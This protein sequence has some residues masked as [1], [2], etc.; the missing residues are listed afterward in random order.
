[1]NQSKLDRRQFLKGLGLGGAGV[2]LAGCD[3]PSYVTLEQGEENVISYL[4]PNEYVIPGVGVWYASTCVGCSAG[5]GIHG[6]V[7]EG[8]VL[9]LEGNPDSGVNMGR[10][11]QMGQAA[12]QHHFNPDRIANPMVRKNGALVEASWDEAIALI[13]EKSK[14]GK[15][16]WV[17]G[18]IS[19]HQRVMAQTHLGAIGGSRH[20]A[21]E[22]INA[23][24]WKTACKDIINDPNPEIHLEKAKVIFS[25]GADF[26][27]TFISPVH[28]AASY[29]EFRTPPRG[30]LIQ[31]EP[32][33]SLT[34][35][36]ADHWVGI[37]P[38]SETA[39]A[40]GVANAL[41]NNHGVAGNGISNATKTLINK[42][43]PETV[44]GI[45]AV[46]VGRIEKIA[47]SLAANSPS[48][49]LAGGSATGNANGYS[50]AAAALMLNQM[51]GNIGTTITAGRELAYP[52]LDLVEGN[53]ANLKDLAIDANE[54]KIDVLFVSGAN[55]LFLAP[56]SL[57]MLEGWNKVGFKVVLSSMLDETAEAA[58]VVLP[59]ASSLEDWGSHIPSYAKGTRN[60]ALQ[61]PLM[62]PVFPNTRGFGDVVLALAKDAGAPGLDDYDDYYGYLRS[63]ISALKKTDSEKEW[64]GFL[65]AG[66]TQIPSLGRK[67]SYSDGKIT[68]TMNDSDDG[69]LTLIAS[70]RMGMW[71]G[72][73][74]NLPWLQESPD[75]ISKV[76]WD[77]WAELHPK[78]AKSLGIKDGDYINIKS[79]SGE[80]T[81]RA[82]I[83]KG[84]HPGA[85]AVPI[86]R[87]HSALG[88]YAKDNGVNPL[89]IL[90]GASDSKT[91]EIATTATKVSVKSAGKNKQ[92]AKLM[93]I[94]RQ[95]GRKLVATISADKQR[96][97]EG[98]A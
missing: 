10:L 96:R 30:T 4:A 20:Y 9:K 27:G 92:M 29:A 51:L 38:G 18:T 85:I 78:T 65:M 34:G 54:G 39:L 33:M 7:R 57:K 35:G 36:N 28:F 26:L 53:S 50:A 87:G 14:S 62:E 47:A 13:N 31:A 91:G 68:P 55:P 44:A 2:A 21:V 66:Q 41:M 45:C 43:D 77:S 40:L 58:D 61:Q 94:D 84:I 67:L 8:R 16:A 22:Q 5:C 72:R 12:L 76:V 19:G 73:G 64:N 95:H 63:A 81:T 89:S 48:L 11:C 60:L 3:L 83:Y 46:P 56:K 15:A 6:R 17:T 75:Q 49:V 23:N 98:G 80:V 74:A 88:R 86:G 71:D 59:L 37:K 24:V 82:F 97:T 25:L 70:A 32:A 1:M 90:N 42:H 79:A 52:Q 69:N 93:E